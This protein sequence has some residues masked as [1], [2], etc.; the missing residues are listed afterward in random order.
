V[1]EVITVS[2]EL[3]LAGRPA[4][5][6]RGQP[7]SVT[8]AAALIGTG[9]PPLPG[10]P[11]GLV[12]SAGGRRAIAACDRVLGQREVVVKPLGPFFDNVGGYIGATILSDGRIALL[13]EPTVLTQGPRP[14]PAA[15]P[16][17]PL[18]PAAAPRILVAEDSFTVRELQRS[19]LEAAGYP[20]VT[21]ND[22]RAALGILGQDPE[23][24]LV[25]TDLDMPEF[26]GLDLTRAIRADQARSLL[27]VIIVTS[28]GS[29]A[30]RRKG[31]EAGADAYIAKDAFD[32][33]TL[34]AAVERL[35][36]R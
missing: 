16:P 19:I 27:P 14:A 11:P 31:I 25:V 3:V 32:Q 9:A 1:L 7:L 15:S 8:D 21:A 36:G 28:N 26:S 13:I 23:I 2:Q 4:L 30:D 29:E 17:P 35:V 33:Q 34:L 5:D 22:G 12:I 24:A 18:P 20:V 6:Y 10:Q